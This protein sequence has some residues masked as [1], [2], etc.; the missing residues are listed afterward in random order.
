MQVTELMIFPL[1]SAGVLR[2]ESAELD[3]YGFKYDRMYMMAFPDPKDGSYKLLTQRE[4][5]RL[6]LI[7]PEIDHDNGK[8]ILTYTPNNARLSLPLNFDAA[9]LKHGEPE[10][11]PTLIWSQTPDSYDLQH[12]FPEI[13]Q[14]FQQI[15]ADNSHLAAN[16]TIVAPKQRRAVLR[17]SPDESV[18]Q[19]L[20]QTNFQDYF[21]GNLNTT[22]S[23]AD[24]DKR[25]RENTNGAIGVTSLNFRANV[26]IS[27]DKP[28]DEDD[29][30]LIRIGST[31]WYVVMRDVR[32][33]VTA[34]NTDT[35]EFNP[36]RE[37]YKTMQSYRRIDPGAKYY[38]CFGMN[39]IHNRLGTI[40]VGDPVEVCERGEHLYE[41]IASVA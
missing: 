1:K 20:P 15:F 29:W 14:F 39:M 31:L 7:T 19:R 38:P 3:N 21:P 5:P 23:I 11:H 26:I 16:G 28:Y 9:K 4:E 40:R 37:P 30:K 35:G 17:G 32:C 27:N 24:L 22:A 25:V 13:R 6:V 2:V 10:S 41:S 33:Q 12:E 34:V 8:L 36:N 18:L